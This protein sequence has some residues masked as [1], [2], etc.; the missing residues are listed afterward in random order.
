MAADGVN[1]S[2]FLEFL[3]ADC[4]HRDI[5]VFLLVYYYQGILDL[6]QLLGPGQRC[7]SLEKLQVLAVPRKGKTDE[8]LETIS[9]MLAL[10]ALACLL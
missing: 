8:L 10:D 1:V 3:N 7:L 4:K 9:A 5:S 2:Q 6:H